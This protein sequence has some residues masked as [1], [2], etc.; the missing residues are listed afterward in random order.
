MS[1][2]TTAGLAAAGK[3][4]LGIAIDLGT[5][6]IAAQIVDLASGNVLGV[7]TEL[8]PQASFGSDV[9]NR[10]RAALAG[11]DL[12]TVVR[13]A[14]GQIVARLAHGREAGDCRSRPRRQHGHASP[15]LRLRR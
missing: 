8:N 4:G 12:T 13:A 6:T 14:L 11:D 9:M 10:I 5:T 3:H 2:R 1:S 15:V 7:E